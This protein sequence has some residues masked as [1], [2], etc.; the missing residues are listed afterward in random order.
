M[1]FSPGSERNMRGR[2]HGRGIRRFRTVLPV[3]SEESRP[4][5][6]EVKAA[7]PHRAAPS[8]APPL[9]RQKANRHGGI[10]AP[11]QTD[12]TVAPPL[13]PR[14]RNIIKKQPAEA[15]RP[16]AD[17]PRRRFHRPPA[18]S[19]P[20]A[21]ERYF[22]ENGGGDGKTNPAPSYSEGAGFTLRPKPSRREH[23]SGDQA[24]PLA[25]L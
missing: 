25:F 2:Q 20:F 24:S 4:A 1:S 12:R 7:Y 22:P 19:P 3:R 8:A 13:P 10:A 11:T 17:R 18:E 16:H 9:N 14:H 5:A 6:E 23:R 21:L 15:R